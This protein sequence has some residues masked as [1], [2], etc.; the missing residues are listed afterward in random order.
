[1]SETPRLSEARLALA[2]GDVE[3]ARE[4]LEAFGREGGRKEA[5]WSLWPMAIEAQDARAIELMVKSG[6]PLSAKG[7]ACPLARAVAAD[8]LISVQA[9]LESGA[10]P[11]ARMDASPCLSW[12]IA[13]GRR[14]A[15]LALLRHGAD[16]NEADAEGFAPL[17]DAA[18]RGLMEVME[19]LIKSGADVMALGP[20]GM[21]AAERARMMGRHECAERLLAARADWEAARLGEAAGR[22]RGGGRRA[23]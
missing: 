4:A 5:L 16:P 20:D 6:A 18:A 14:E 19:A 3:A 2:R 8:C 21:V 12:A 11:G 22:A 17:Y 23:L 1:M 9:L 7:S 15:A 10:D 13:R